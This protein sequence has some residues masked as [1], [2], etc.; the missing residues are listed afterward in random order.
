MCVHLNLSAFIWY[1]EISVMCFVCVCIGSSEND[2]QCSAG[3]EEECS[4]FETGVST[5]V[6]VYVV[7]CGLLC[8]TAES[9]KSK[10]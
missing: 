1:F 10:R 8:V 2:L 9:K 4:H 6:T 5:C 3:I 7:C